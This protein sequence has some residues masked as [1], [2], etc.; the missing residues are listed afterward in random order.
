MCD[1][2]QPH[3]QPPPGIACSSALRHMSNFSKTE[4]RTASHP[5]PGS[6]KLLVAKHTSACV[7]PCRSAG[8]RPST[9]CP[10]RQGALLT[11]LHSTHPCSWALC[12]PQFAVRPPAAPHPP[13]PPAL[14][15]CGA[16]LRQRGTENLRI[17][18]ACR[19]SSFSRAWRKEIGVNGRSE[20]MLIGH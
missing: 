11:T 19:S 14:S 16:L 2:K 3:S 4:K 17:V 20:G 6:L 1:R 9:S 8:Q 18:L 15:V 12:S 10:P 7:K 5:P 13:S